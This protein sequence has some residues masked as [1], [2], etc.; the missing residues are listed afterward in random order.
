MDIKQLRQF[1]TVLRA[2]S[3]SRAAVTLGVAQPILTKQIQMLEEHLGENLLYRNGRGVIPTQAGRLLETYAETI[4][5]AT[6]EAECAIRSLSA[7]P[8]GEIVIGIPPMI[9]ESL[10]VP[11]VDAF[12]SEFPSIS[13]RVVEA[14]SGYIL[15]W[16]T[17]GRLDVGIVYNIARTT[18]QTAEPLV[19]EGLYLAAPACVSIDP[20]GDTV[21]PAE[22]ASVPLVLPNQPNG[23]RTLVDSYLSR[24]G[25]KPNIVVEVDGL[26][27]LIRLV[28]HGIGATVMSSG[29]AL[30]YREEG[31]LR[32]W[33]IASPPLTGEFYLTTST[34]RPST[35]I[36]RRL[37]KIVQSKAK[38]LSEA[39]GWRPLR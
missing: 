25:A 36:T 8:K 14:Y 23:L 34:Q 7:A 20:P 9:G 28:E 1:V 16:L 13:L 32:V 15:E 26:S 33:Q 39:N 4:L 2:G 24:H 18:F 5:T 19:E 30:R 10:T 37:V 6:S 11:V 12:R 3:L 22:I 35:P 27:A 31:K 17:S 38:M 29:L 21:G